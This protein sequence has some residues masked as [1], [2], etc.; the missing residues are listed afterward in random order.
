M[1]SPTCTRR[2]NDGLNTEPPSHA[3]ETYKKQNHAVPPVIQLCV[4]QLWALHLQPVCL[5]ADHNPP[6][7]LS[8]P[9]SF[10]PSFSLQQTNTR[11]SACRKGHLTVPSQCERYTVCIHFGTKHSQFHLA[12]FFH[13]GS[14]TH[15]CALDEMKALS[16]WCSRAALL[17]FFFYFLSPPVCSSLPHHGPLK[18]LSLSSISFGCYH[19]CLS[20]SS[21]SS[22]L[23]P[24]AESVSPSFS[25]CF[26]FISSP[27]ALLPSLSLRPSQEVFVIIEH[28]E[29]LWMTPWKDARGKQ[30]GKGLIVIRINPGLTKCRCFECRATDAAVPFA[31]LPLCH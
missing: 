11:F 6:H 28:M 9:S 20:P 26:L 22:L 17:P 16:A 5:T 2:H 8:V 23:A 3:A 27:S 19:P 7:L 14:C 25:A 18:S 15:R 1:P 29:L 12:S 31:K 4:L 13:P 10:S 24:W 21:K 30:Q